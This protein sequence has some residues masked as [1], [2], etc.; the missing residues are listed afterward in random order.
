MLPSDEVFATIETIE[1][2]KRKKNLSIVFLLFS[3]LRSRKTSHF[4]DVGSFESD[5]WTWFNAVKNYSVFN[6]RIKKEGL[7]NQRRKN[8]ISLV[9]NSKFSKKLRIRVHFNGKIRWNF[10]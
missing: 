6:T 5:V 2:C 3:F 8:S 7:K 9:R 4:A 10:C 1:R